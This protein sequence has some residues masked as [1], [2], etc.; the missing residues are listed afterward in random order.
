MF[1]NANVSHQTRTIHKT[2]RVTIDRYI[3]KHIPHQEYI[4]G[5]YG[6]PH[7]PRFLSFKA[8]CVMSDGK[9]FSSGGTRLDNAD[10]FSTTS[11]TTIYDPIKG[12]TQLLPPS[13]VKHSHSKCAT[14]Y[15]GNI[16]LVPGDDFTALLP[17][18]YIYDIRTKSWI[19]KGPM[20]GVTLGKYSAISTLQDGR[21]I[22]TG[23]ADFA[24][25][26]HG[27]VKVY[28]PFLDT[29]T[30]DPLVINDIPL[31]LQ[32]H[33]QVTLDNGNVFIVGGKSAGGSRT[34]RCYI[35]DISTGVWTEK[36]RLPIT[37]VDHT[38]VKLQNGYPLVIGGD[39]KNAIIST[40]DIV[41]D[42]LVVMYKYILEDNRW[43]TESSVKPNIQTS[44]AHV[45]H[46]G[47][48]LVVPGRQIEMFNSGYLI[49]NP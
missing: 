10:T 14:L 16:L 18:Y 30:E 43:V 15:N 9:I 6:I 5:R 25:T 1:D 20:V 41:A 47:R 17:N 34:F 19:D 29:W 49:T 3:W 31:T 23:G 36:Q 13:L 45:L 33:S 2:F 26:P 37:I 46:D 44:D 12:T 22:I 21:V 7:F 28:D 8:T 42:D 48:L 24:G 27:K 35:L 11:I 32:K 40:D 38:M 4:I 39:R